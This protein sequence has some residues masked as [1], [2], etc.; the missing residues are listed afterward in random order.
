MTCGISPSLHKVTSHEY[1]IS[2][3]DPR[4]TLLIEAKKHHIAWKNPD[5]FIRAVIA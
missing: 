4:D 1:Y 5:L 3:D 2:G